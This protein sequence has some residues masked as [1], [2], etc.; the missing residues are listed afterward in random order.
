MERIKQTCSALA[1]MI[2][3][4]GKIRNRESSVRQGRKGGWVVMALHGRG[5]AR[6]CHAQPDGS[7]FRLV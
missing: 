1:C 7:V 3:D 5:R 2:S 6:L 4:Q